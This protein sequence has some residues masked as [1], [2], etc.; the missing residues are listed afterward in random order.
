MLQEFLKN[1]I[2]SDQRGLIYDRIIGSRAWIA[3]N[4]KLQPHFNLL[5]CL[6]TG[7][8]NYHWAGSCLS[9]DLLQ[10]YIPMASLLGWMPSERNKTQPHHL[11]LL[12]QKPV[13]TGEQKTINK[14]NRKCSILLWRLLNS[15][16]C[17]PMYN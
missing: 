4:F 8:L 15:Q 11:H 17:T 10:T 13:A 5:P 1:K 12:S 7:I 9:H 2:I 14:I 16:F 6:T 3:H